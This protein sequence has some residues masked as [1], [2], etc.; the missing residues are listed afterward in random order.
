MNRS[1]LKATDREAAH[2]DAV[3]RERERD[4]VHIRVGRIARLWATDPGSNDTYVA[5]AAVVAAAIAWS[6][7]ACV[8]VRSATSVSKYGK[9]F[10]RK[11]KKPWNNDV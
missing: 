4:A 2:G 3:G 5:P 1:P 7:Y 6:M 9:A 11:P 8:S 10:V